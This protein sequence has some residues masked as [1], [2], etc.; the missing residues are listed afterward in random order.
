MTPEETRREA[1]VASF[2]KELRL[3]E[4]ATRL[5]LCGARPL[6]IRTIC[7]KS[8]G[9]TEIRRIFAIA[10]PHRPDERRGR[11]V[12]SNTSTR[13]PLDLQDFYS[14]VLLEAERVHANGALAAD[15]VT[16]VWRF[17]AENAQL[18]W[19]LALPNGAKADQFFALWTYFQAKR[20]RINEAKGKYTLCAP[21][22]EELGRLRMLEKAFEQRQRMRA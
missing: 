1:R 2:R 5:V 20:L 17:H 9:P 10:T 3:L 16:A 12:S 19:H 21:D 15:A 11:A 13:L 7:H 6:V 18:A 22:L 8:L 4:M 14:R